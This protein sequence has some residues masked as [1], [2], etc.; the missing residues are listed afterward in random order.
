MAIDRVSDLVVY[1]MIG[2]VRKIVDALL[3]IPVWIWLT[4]LT[5]VGVNVVV[6]LIISQF[7]S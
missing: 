2:C 4:W 7:T 6:V 1:V 3:S 5:Y